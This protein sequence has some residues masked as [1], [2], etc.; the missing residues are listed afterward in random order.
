MTW[1]I[2]MIKDSLIGI[3]I[4]IALSI[5]IAQAATISRYDPIQGVDEL[6]EFEFIKSSW[7]DIADDQKKEVWYGDKDL[8]GEL[9]SLMV[10]KYISVPIT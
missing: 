6:W 3:G 5:N 8:A 10:E 2:R 9:V 1:C 7:A 4:M